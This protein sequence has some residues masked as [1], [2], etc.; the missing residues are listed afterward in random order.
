MQQQNNN[1]KNQFD[2]WNDENGEMNIYAEKIQGIQD[3]DELLSFEETIMEPEEK[4]INSFAE[5][6]FIYEDWQKKDS[7]LKKKLK[8]QK[9]DQF[10]NKCQLNASGEFVDSE[11]QRRAVEQF[12][13][14][15]HKE[16]KSSSIWN[17]IKGKAAFIVE[18]SPLKVFKLFRNKEKEVQKKKDELLKKTKIQAELRTKEMYSL[19]SGMNQKE[20]Y[21]SLK[22][23]QEEMAGQILFDYIKQ[24]RNS[25]K[26]FCRRSIPGADIQTRAY[27]ESMENL[28]DNITKYGSYDKNNKDLRESL[29]QFDDILKNHYWSKS[30]QEEINKWFSGTEGSQATVFAKMM[31]AN[32]EVMKT[33]LKAE[34]KIQRLHQ[35]SRTSVSR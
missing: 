25:E 24:N 17:W 7:E 33:Q 14:Q 30:H 3:Y 27:I 32:I 2:F 11:S 23:I 29:C 21:A 28:I 6:K 4:R 10:I 15:L 9:L 22:R 8:E 35:S 20:K 16:S 26:L 5:N 34:D 18:H 12:K 31:N 1:Y 19:F 13:T